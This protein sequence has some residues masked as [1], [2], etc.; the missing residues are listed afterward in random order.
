MTVWT[1]VV[2]GTPPSGVERRELSQAY[3]RS[4]TMRVD[5]PFT[6]QFSLD[7]RSSQAAEI[8]ALATDL[9]VYRNGVKYFRGRITTESD[10]VSESEHACQFTATCYRGMLDYREIGTAGASFAAV[11]QG[12][13]AFN[14]IAASQALA[15]GNWGIT[16]GVGATSG[17]VRD[18]TY[19][20]GKPLGE[21]IAELFRVDNG[22]E[23]EISPTLA[24]NRWYPK[25]GSV[26]SVVLDYGGKVARADRLLSPRDFANFVVVS[27][28]QGLTPTSAVTAG[29]ATDPRGRWEI[30]LGLPSVLEQATLTTKATWLLAQSSTLRPEIV[31]TL[32]PGRWA[33]LTDIALG[34]TVALGL[35]SGRLSDTGA[36]RVVEINCAPDEDGG[37]QITMGLVAA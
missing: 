17:T 13:I 15:G 5:A 6:A 22:G 8:V 19:D 32:T 11:D 9:H 3:G 24:L 16:D 36:F 34:D 10:T 35:R 25:R 20:P 27:G 1:W 31:V 33:G 4:L 30:S 37:E 26:T 29:I 28:S 23:W 7:G 12:T 2:G 14:L 21:A 18:R